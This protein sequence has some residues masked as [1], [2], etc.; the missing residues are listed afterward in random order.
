[1]DI[2]LR[3]AQTVLFVDQIC[4]H[5]IAKAPALGLSQK[6]CVVDDLHI[7]ALFKF[8]DLLDLAQKPTIDLAKLV[9]LIHAHARSKAL[10]NI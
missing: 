9:N 3:K 5:L 10:S 7:D 2:V 8:Y 4:D 6:R 1:M